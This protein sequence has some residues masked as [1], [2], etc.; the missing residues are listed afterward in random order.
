MCSSSE[1]HNHLVAIRNYIFSNAVR[2]HLYD[3]ENGQVTSSYREHYLKTINKQD[4]VWQLM[5]VGKG[6]MRSN[7]TEVSSCVSVS[8][9][10]TANCVHNILYAVTVQCTSALANSTVEHCH[11]DNLTPNVPISFVY[12]LQHVIAVV[13]IPC[14]PFTDNKPMMHVLS[15]G[16]NLG[17]LSITRHSHSCVFCVVHF[18]SPKIYNSVPPHVLQSRTVALFS[19]D[20]T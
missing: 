16:R 1:E 20:M 8:T 3:V 14:Q 11:N 10:N 13:I 17:L 5:Q 4:A 18:T 6:P 15:S 19:L 12:V 9:D 2:Q 7:L